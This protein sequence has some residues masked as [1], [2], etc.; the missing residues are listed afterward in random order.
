VDQ[1]VPVPQPIPAVL[2]VQCP[3]LAQWTLADLLYLS[4][5]EDLLVL[6][7]LVV[8]LSRSVQDFQLLHEYLARQENLGFLTFH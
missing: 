7:D 5:P 8:L 4:P 1:Q 3:L 6:K 2:V